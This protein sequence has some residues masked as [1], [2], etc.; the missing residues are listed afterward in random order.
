MK[1]RYLMAIFISATILFSC[2][3]QTGQS[4]TAQN[5]S[6]KGMNSQSSSKDTKLLNPVITPNNT[7]LFTYIVVDLAEERRNKMPAYWKKE[8]DRGT[9][10]LDE[11]R[12]RRKPAVVI[13]RRKSV[14]LSQ[15]GSKLAETGFCRSGHT[16]INS[17]FELARS[18]VKGKCND[19]A[20]PEDR[21][22]FS[23]AI[24]TTAEFD[25]LSEGLLDTP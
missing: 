20:T 3:S 11:T 18:T 15:L 14:I 19:S 4:P 1:K 13:E 9:K 23:S 16:I 22:K 5:T 7:K 24:S 10:S 21:V 6:S 12:K 17:H 8:V 2:S 25:S